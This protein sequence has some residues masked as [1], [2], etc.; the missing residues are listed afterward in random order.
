MGAVF[1]WAQLPAFGLVLTGTLA[2][3][4]VFQ[5]RF[6]VAPPLDIALRAGL[7][8]LALAALFH[9]DDGIAAVFAG[10]TLLMLA[11]GLWRFRART[12]APA[13]PSAAPRGPTT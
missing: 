11:V 9:P 10:A 7:A 1:S 8:V 13:P 12:R 6:D 3:S 5:G 4:F 2:L